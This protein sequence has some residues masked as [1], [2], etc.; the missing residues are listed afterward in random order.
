M[1]AQ[2]AH[3]ETI[4]NTVSAQEARPRLPGWAALHRAHQLARWSGLCYTIPWD[5][6]PARLQAERLRLVAH[7]RNGYTA[8]R[9]LPHA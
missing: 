2:I 6:L 5:E 8:W 4:C 9:V 7:G 3:L 1:A